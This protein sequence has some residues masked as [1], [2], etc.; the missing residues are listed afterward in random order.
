[1]TIQ[2]RLSLLSLALVCSIR[3]NAA[4]PLTSLVSENAPVVITVSDFPA[5]KKAWNEGPWGRAMEDEQLKKFLSPLRA[6]AKV[7]EWDEVTKRETG[8]TVSE[9]LG[10]ATGEV[11]IALQSGEGLADVKDPSGV[12]VLF[13]IQLG[14]NASK[15]EK[16]INEAASKDSKAAVS[17]EDFAGV[18]VYLSNFGEE[19][20]DKEKA[21]AW[22]FIDGIGL[23]GPS[24]ATVLSAIDAVK[25]G[26]LGN[27]LARSERF[28]RAQSGLKDAQALFFFNLHAII[29]AAQAAIE[30]KRAEKA[31]EG[32]APGMDPAA[33]FKA[34]GLDVL[35]TLYMGFAI[36]DQ[37]TEVAGGLTYTEQRGIVK[38]LAYRDGPPPTPDFVPATWTTVSTGNFSFKAMYAAVEEM[39]AAFNPMISSMV[40]SR[41][42]QFN[43]TLGIDVKR[44]LIGSTGDA[45]M[46]ATYLPNGPDGKPASIEALQ[47]FIAISLENPT[48]FANAI[49]AIK[50]MMG[51]Q[52]EKIFVKREYLGTDLF[53]FQPPGQPQG[54]G[55]SYAI[56]PKFL[57]LSIGSPAMVE[58]AIQGKASEQ[59]RFWD[60]PEVKAALAEIPADASAFEFQNTGVL[61]AAALDAVVAAQAARPAA[62]A[63]GDEAAEEPATPAR[64]FD[65]SA[66]PDAAFIAKYLGNTSG[67]SR[68]D[69]NG[70]YFRSKLN[71]AK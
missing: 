14:D 69:S 67:Y 53:T 54:R 21:A 9:L 5:L 64:A 7:E 31:A 33:V 36:G 60:K 23:F 50:G 45:V 24:K 13:A 12:P 38:L 47:Q 61:L 15:V 51:P 20:S 48:A 58:A 1:M 44:D 43:K 59:P 34:L 52:S 37:S 16:L 6:Q 26:G 71:H 29:P 28:M 39:L 57:L 40:Q 17:T 27:S 19:E 4:V 25:N 55:W 49:G 63:E 41:I 66:K 8:Y 62:P 3:L 65:A 11:L 18:T 46:S 32:E 2:R 68:H 30:T 22:A 56:T 35:D 42:A 70:I 10:F